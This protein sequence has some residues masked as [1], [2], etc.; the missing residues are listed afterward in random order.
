MFGKKRLLFLLPLMLISTLQ[1]NDP[2]G[3]A[4]FKE[5]Y[6][7]QKEMDQLFERMQQRAIQST[8]Q[9]ATM[10]PIPDNT[11][12]GTSGLLEDKG[13]HYEYNTQIKEGQN[14]QI[15]ISIENNILHFKASTDISKNENQPHGQT[16]EHFVSMIQRSQVLPDDADAGSLKSAYVNG[17]LVI[18]LQKSKSTKQAETNSTIQPIPAFQSDKEP[19]RKENN[20]TKITV[21]HTSSHA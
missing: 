10:A 1:A 20:D 14:S 9:Y 8:H 17:I 2:F 13:T 15:T 21:P 3:E 6:Q 7:M 4:I 18:S 11:L 19:D 12:T 5:M 16:Q